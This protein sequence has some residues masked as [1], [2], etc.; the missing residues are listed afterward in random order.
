MSRNMTIVVLILVVMEYDIVAEEWNDYYM[1]DLS[2]LI[3]VVMEYDIVVDV[4]DFESV[5]DI[6]RL[7]PCCNGI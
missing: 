7:N 5:K 6:V 1:F 2:V 4:A 3:L